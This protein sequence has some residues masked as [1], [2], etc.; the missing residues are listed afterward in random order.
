[1]K[2]LHRSDLFGWSEFNRDRNID[3][4]SVLW[5]RPSGNVAIDPLPLTDHDRNHLS[6]LG[7][8]AWI[9]ITNS[10]HTRDALALAERSGAKLAGPLGERASFPF[11]C[12][13]WLSDGDEIVPGLRALT[14]EGSKTMGELA[15]VLDD[16]TLITGDL[17]RAHEGG[18]LTLLPDAKLADR[19]RAVAAVARLAALERIEAVLPGDGW[20]IFRHGR[21]ALLEL[22]NVLGR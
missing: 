3:F 16:T 13:R 10:D 7:P 17:V 20:P 11:P 5:V 6:T 22:S 15:L 21:E 1:M 8:L 2:R 12:E 9:V 19:A 14:V 4:H 18:R